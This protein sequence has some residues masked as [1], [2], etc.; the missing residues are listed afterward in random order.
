MQDKEEGGEN[1]KEMEKK[2]SLE[3]NVAFVRCAGVYVAQRT[4]GLASC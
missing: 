3:N 4:G 1:K 2:R